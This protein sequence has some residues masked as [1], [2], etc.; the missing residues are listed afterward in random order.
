MK[1]A[2]IRRPLASSGHHLA[3]LFPTVLL[4]LCLTTGGAL[5]HGMGHGGGRFG[6]G[7]VG[8]G[9]F[10]GSHFG[11]LGG[12]HVGRFSGSFAGGRFGAGHFASGQFRGRFSGGRFGH[13]RP[14]RVFFHHGRRFPVFFAFG[15]PLVVPYYA[16]APYPYYY[17]AYCDP[18][19]A[20]YDPNYC[21]WQHRV[22]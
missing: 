22:Y 13:F 15:F 20:Y 5:A 21:Y 11:S 14:D 7:H 6:G 18:Y 16:Y 1:L 17:D 12:S 19:S 4:L 8:A 2:A 9:G 3:A 10:G